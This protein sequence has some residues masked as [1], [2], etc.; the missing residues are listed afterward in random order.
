MFQL[1]WSDASRWRQAATLAP[2]RRSELRRGDFKRGLLLRWEE[3]CVECAVP[4]C[5]STCPLYEGRRDGACRRLE[6]GIA[7]NRAFDGRFDFG[8]DVRFKRWGKIEAELRY[9]L[10]GPLLPHGM[11][12]L[13]H[14]LPGRVRIALGRWVNRIVRGGKLDYDELVIECHSAEREPFR[15][16]MEHFVPTGNGSRLTRSRHVLPIEPGYNLHRLPFEQLNIGALEGVIFLHPE[17]DQT[18]RR[19]VFTWLDVVKRRTPAAIETA[20]ERP[21]A[22]V[23]CVAWDL[24]NTLWHGILVES[25]EVRPRAE[26]LRLIEALDARGIVQTVVSKNDHDNAWAVVKRLGLDDY[27]LYPAIN[28]G[29]KSENLKEIARHLN[30]GLDTFAVIDDSPF[31]REEISQALPQVRIHPETEIGSLLERAEFDVPVTETSKN[32]RAMYR[33]E[34]QRKEIGATF[35]GS[36]EDF[37]VSCRMEMQIFKP[38]DDADR[39]RCW[40]LLQRSNQLNLSSVR[41]SREEFDAILADDRVLGLAIRCRDKFGD[42]GIVGFTTTDLGDERPMIRDFVISCRV[43]QKRVEHTYVNWLAG[44]L[45]S[46]G[47]HEMY[48]R[49]VRTARNKPIRQVFE[50][51]AFECVEEESEDTSILKL[52][53]ATMK[54]MREVIRLEVLRVT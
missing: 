42:Y 5:Y 10:D 22:K 35:S 24:D 8:A 47:R 21:A 45:Q 13:Y 17:E 30:I 43:A 23:K 9:G 34:A 44:Y 38:A 12:R 29:Q 49:L 39:L 36:Y 19:V 7:A 16:L 14:R 53:L 33:A 31:E 4:D 2:T 51:L 20:R 52:D 1:E 18:Q 6:W 50:D 26:A 48:A 54:P 41:H 46:I 11:L 27:F 15:M 37:I 32:R 3:H 28:W 25:P 40:E